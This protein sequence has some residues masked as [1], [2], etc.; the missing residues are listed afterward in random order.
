MGATP[1]AAE[2]RPAPA[3]NTVCGRLVAADGGVYRAG[4]RI[5]GGF[6]APLSG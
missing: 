6:A 1:G 2:P 5:S 4:A 3:R